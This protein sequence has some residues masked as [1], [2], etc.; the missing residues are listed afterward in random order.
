MAVHIPKPAVI[1]AAGNKKKIIREFF[2]RVSSKHSE[3]SI[4]CMK[5]PLGWEEPGQQPEF[6][7]YTVVLKGS[8]KIE[9]VNKIFKIKA[10]QAFLASAGEWVRYSSPWKGGAEYL[11]V[12]LP[13]FSISSVHRD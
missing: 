12:C 13:A 2:G 3:V 9:T 4:A 11:A 10:G 6:D 1:K 8:L 5:S 7:E